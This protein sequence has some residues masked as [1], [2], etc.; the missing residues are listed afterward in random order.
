M[1]DVDI[2]QVNYDGKE[3]TIVSCCC[4]PEPIVLALIEKYGNA[5]NRVDIEGVWCEHCEGEIRG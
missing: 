2:K 1:Y 3:K 5:C 4:V